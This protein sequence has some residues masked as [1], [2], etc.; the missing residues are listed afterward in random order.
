MENPKFSIIT[1]VYN[2]KQYLPKIIESLENQSYKS[3]EW[4]VCDDG[5]DDGTDE[6]FRKNIP[7][8]DGVQTRLEYQYLRQRHKG[9]LSKNIN[10]GIRKA[11]GEYL[12]FIMGDSFPETNYLEVLDEWVNPNYVIC[13]IR[14]NIEGRRVVEMD[15]RLRKGLIPQTPVLLVNEPWNLATGNGLT[16]PRQALEKQGWDERFKVG[17]EDNEIIARLFY[18]GYLIWSVPQLIIYHNYHRNALPKEIN[19]N[20]LNKIIRKYAS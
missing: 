15:Y 20:L 4:I 3:F 18:Q 5:S 12:V 7:D 11:R 10:Q 6:F 17:G 2:Q 16:I 9:N 14:V 8:L 13:G 1:A 19:N